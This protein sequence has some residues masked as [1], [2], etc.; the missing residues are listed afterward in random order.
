[1]QVENSDNYISYIKYI[2]TNIPVKSCVSTAKACNTARFIHKVQSPQCCLV[3]ISGLQKYTHPLNHKAMYSTCIKQN[4]PRY[5]YMH[6]I[7]CAHAYIKHAL[8][9]TC[10]H[11]YML[12]HAC[13]CTCMWYV[14]MYIC[15]CVK[16]QLTET[17][18]PHPQD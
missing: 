18:H 10:L 5:A 15:W 6:I 1:M 9:C 17:L 8:A 2:Y 16:P 4:P 14:W 12:L 11:V 3:G 7:I 13:T